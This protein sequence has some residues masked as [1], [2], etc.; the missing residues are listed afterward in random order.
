MNLAQVVTESGQIT[1]P[2]S[3]P[4]QVP[5]RLKSSID[6][7]ARRGMILNILSSGPKTGP[8]V[9]ARMPEA[10]V[11]LAYAMLR[12]MSFAGHIQRTGERLNYVYRLPE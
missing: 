2:A 5:P 6:P 4:L 10:N 9:I 12:D 1:M 8:E 11:K 7:D 3:A